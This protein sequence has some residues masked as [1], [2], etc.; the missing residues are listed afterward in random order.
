[1]LNPGDAVFARETNGIPEDNIIQ[2]WVMDIR[3]VHVVYYHMNTHT[4]SVWS[5]GNLKIMMI[6]TR[7][8]VRG[9][10]ENMNAHLQGFWPPHGYIRLEVYVQHNPHHRTHHRNIQYPPAWD[11]HLNGWDG[12]SDYRV[13]RTTV[14]YC[15]LM[16]HAVG[17][18]ILS[19]DQCWTISTK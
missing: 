7:H 16:C 19:L 17:Y 3:C 5:K 13:F 6:Q 14:S 2:C 1:M 8:W 18:Q 9:S 10:R 12:F 4:Y 15:Y 11:I